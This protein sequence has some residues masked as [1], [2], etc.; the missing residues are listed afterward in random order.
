MLPIYGVKAKSF[1]RQIH[2]GG[3]YE[4]PSKGIF[5]TI[6]EVAK[7]SFPGLSI[8]SQSITHAW[9]AADDCSDS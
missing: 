1:N 6:A 9:G 7:W 8:K 2:V 3:T 5:S 4:L